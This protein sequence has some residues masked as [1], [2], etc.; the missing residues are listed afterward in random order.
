MLPPFVHPHTSLHY[1]AR[2]GRTGCARAFPRAAARELAAGLAQTPAFQEDEC[3]CE[4]VVA[5]G[6]ID[7][8]SAAAILPAACARTTTRRASL[9][10]YHLSISIFRSTVVVARSDAVRAKQPQTRLDVWSYPV[11]WTLSPR[12]PLGARPVSPRARVVVAFVFDLPDSRFLPTESEIGEHVERVLRKC[13]THVTRV[14]YGR[15]GRPDTSC[16]V[17]PT[18]GEGEGAYVEERCTL[19]ETYWKEV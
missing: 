16:V 17:R 13:T 14:L 9:F 10:I 8:L 1:A 7:A 5:R 3:H 15:Q 18:H 11:D 19:G 12:R 6:L 4:R 2:R